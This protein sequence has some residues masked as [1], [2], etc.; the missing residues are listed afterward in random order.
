M[1]QIMAESLAIPPGAQ[2]FVHHLYL[3]FF[4]SLSPNKN[5]KP[6]SVPCPVLPS[7]LVCLALVPSYMLNVC[8]FTFVTNIY[9]FDFLCVINLCLLFLK[10][11]RKP[12]NFLFLFLSIYVAI[13]IYVLFIHGRQYMVCHRVRYY[14]QWAKCEMGIIGCEVL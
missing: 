3:L 2:H 4:I 13:Y 1:L 5:Y 7:F 14:Y 10:V 11:P 8:A 12:S 6:L 9:S